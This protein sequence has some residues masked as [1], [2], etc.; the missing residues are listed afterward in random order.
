MSFLEMY[1]RP[2]IL[3][4]LCFLIFNITTVIYKF[5]LTV[6]G[7]SYMFF[8]HDKTWPTQPDPASVFDPIIKAAGSDSSIEKKTIIFVRH[9]ESTWNDTFNKGSHRSALA[10]AIGYVPGLIKSLLYEFYLLLSGKI[11]SWFYDSPLSH[12]GLSQVKSLANFLNQDPHSIASLTDEERQLLRILRRDPKSP[13]SRIVSS[14]LRRALSTVAASFQGRLLRDPQESILILP[15][16]Q[17]ISRNPDTLSIT[18]AQTK[19]KPSW[20]EVSSDVCDFSS[21]FTKQVDMQYHLGNKPIDTNGLKRMMKFNQ[22]VFS[23]SLPE[24]YIIVGGHS[25]WFRSFFREF[26]PRGSGHVG[27]KKKIVN[28]GAVALDLWKTTTTDDGRDMF[29]IDEKS[30]RVVYGGFK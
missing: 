10:F 16:L 12:L 17:E 2:M 15:C 4:I 9:G 23:S 27:K 30:I 19:V 29:M 13:P 11:D 28:C 5:R 6:Q 3:A 24:D 20:I 1:L 18:P 7:V 25:I 26:L 14:N 22:T 21:I 8:C